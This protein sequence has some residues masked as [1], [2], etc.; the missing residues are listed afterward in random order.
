M[1][2]VTKSRGEDP[3]P[4]STLYQLVVALQKYLWINKVHWQIVEGHKFTDLFENCIGQC[5]VGKNEGQHW[6]CEVP[7]ASNH[8]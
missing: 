7:S 1:P 8:L 5:H 4:A 3:Y 6:C 2:E